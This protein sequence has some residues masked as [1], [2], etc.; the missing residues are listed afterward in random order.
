MK[1]SV[2]GSGF[3]GSTAAYSLVMQGIGREIVLVDHVKARAIAEAADITHAVPFTHPLTI[4]AGDYP[5]V[6][7]SAVVIISAGVGQKPGESRL[8]LLQR[9]ADVFRDCIPKVIEHAP[10]AV[11]LVASNPVD[12]MTHIAGEI[13]A[14]CG[15]P[16]SRV[17]GSGTTLDTAR[18][19][20]LLGDHFGIDSRHIHSQVIGEHGDSE[21]LTWS[22]A[23]I[24]GLSLEEFSEV[25]GI[26]LNDAVRK[27]IDERVRK[28]AYRIIEG[29]GA[30]YYGIG[31]AL[32]RIVDVVLHD[33]RSIMTICSRIE[34]VAGIENITIS[35]PH[36]FGGEG[37]MASI[38]LMLD[39]SEQASLK[40]SATIVRDVIDSIS[41]KV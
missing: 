35:M 25:R 17:I 22:L 11:L 9:N 10:D 7:R 38:P 27:S 31:S 29:K 30:T 3:V 18:F 13:A 23:T 1:V 4:R 14:E 21:V 20:S 26:E 15:V 19:R 34:N 5:D 24:C 40:A 33:Q 2:V 39:D 6:K 36:L 16:S 8:E 41:L 12:I 37:V 28:A 32:A